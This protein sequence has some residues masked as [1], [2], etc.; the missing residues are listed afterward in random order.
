MTSCSVQTRLSKEC[1]WRDVTAKQYEEQLVRDAFIT[2]LAS[3]AI[4]QRLLGN[5]NLDLTTAVNQARALDVA[6]RN[7]QEFASLSHAA[8]YATAD[9]PSISE[10]P[11]ALAM[12][13]QILHDNTGIKA[14][15][16][17]QA[18]DKTVCPAKLKTCFK[19]QKQGH[20]AGVCKSR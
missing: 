8:V 16:C 15:C 11:C 13:K 20:Y 19:F 18:Y 3:P 14:I 9:A 17:V 1:E 2:G 6:H 10:E 4:N 5:E 7:S 12:T